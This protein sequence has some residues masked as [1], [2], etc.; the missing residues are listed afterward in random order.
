MFICNPGSCWWHINHLGWYYSWI[1]HALKHCSILCCRMSYLIFLLGMLYFILLPLQ[2]NNSHILNKFWKNSLGTCPILMSN[3]VAYIYINL[4]RFEFLT[5]SSIFEMFCKEY[6]FYMYHWLHFK[7]ISNKLY[8]L[9]LLVFDLHGN[10]VCSRA[11]F[12]S[13]PW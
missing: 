2:I 8:R 9:I 12:S 13:L 6:G 7:K 4:S 3:A 10:P 1:N 11:L 5:L